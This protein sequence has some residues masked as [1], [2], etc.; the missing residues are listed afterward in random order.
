MEGLVYGST[1]GSVDVISWVEDC[2]FSGVSFF[3]V[4]VDGR[5]ANAIT[6]LMSAWIYLVIHIYL[7]VLRC[8]LTADSIPRLR[9]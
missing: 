1:L 7:S 9:L 6:L 3:I 2:K 8:N 5:L 4:N